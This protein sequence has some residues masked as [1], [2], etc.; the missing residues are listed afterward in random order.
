MAEPEP[1][2]EIALQDELLQLLYW[3]E[4]EGFRDAASPAALA[5][6]LSD[7]GAEVRRALD[8]LAEHGAVTPEPDGLQYRL[9]ERGRREAGRRFAEE[10]DPLLH[11]GHGA[12]HDPDC[13]CHGDPAEA[14]ACRSERLNS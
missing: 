3:V 5:R 14:A 6:F 2:R 12:C 1:G 8:R 13:G 10:F 4:G 7:P 11:Q 9:T